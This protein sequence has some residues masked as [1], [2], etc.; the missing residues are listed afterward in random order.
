[1]Q[2]ASSEW[3]LG[4]QIHDFMNPYNVEIINGMYCCCDDN[5]TCASSPSD[6]LVICKDP[7]AQVCEP[8]FLVHVKNCLYCS[9]SKTYILLNYASN[10][11]TFDHGILSIPFVEMELSDEVRTEI[12]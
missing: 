7:I 1:M 12:S 8:Y 6:L 4:V 10:A 3:F 9:H 2:V 5:E 11:F